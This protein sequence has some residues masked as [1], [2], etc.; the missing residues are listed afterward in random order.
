MKPDKEH[1]LQAGLVWLDR[2]DRGEVENQPALVSEAIVFLDLQE[3]ITLHEQ[4]LGTSAALRDR[5]ALESALARARNAVVYD[6]ATAEQAGWLVAEGIV[7]NHPFT[8]GNKR[9]ALLALVA[10]W[11]KNNV[12]VPKDGVWLA[13]KVLAMTGW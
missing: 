1:W 5:A 2:Y 13:R 9:T 3:V 6:N 11:Q 8:N 7:K 12:P 10:I 4:A